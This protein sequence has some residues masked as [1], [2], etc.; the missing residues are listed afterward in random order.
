[1]MFLEGAE[2][3]ESGFGEVLRNRPVGPGSRHPLRSVMREKDEVSG[4]VSRVA[5]AGKRSG[6]ADVRRDYRVSG[7]FDNT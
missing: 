7:T 2:P 4:D 3:A 5:C 1:M 6:D